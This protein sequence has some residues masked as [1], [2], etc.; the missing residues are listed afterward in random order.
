MMRRAWPGDTFG[1]MQAV[2]RL[3]GHDQRVIVDAGLGIAGAGLIAVAAWGA[4]RLIGS[5]AITGPWWLLA[6]LPLLLGVPLILRR[7]APLQ[8]WL[9]IWAVVA[10][11]S[12]F[13]DN[14]LRGLAFTFVLFAAAYSLGAHASLRRAVVGL[15][16]VA[17]VVVEISHHGRL[18]LAFAQ[19]GG[20]KAVVL[21]LLQLVAFWLAGVFV[22]ARRQAASLAA[23]SAA[24]QRQAD[25]AT[26]AERA[27]IAREMH[28]IV[29]HHLSVI[30]LQAAGAR[31]SGKPAG[32]T[33][34]KIENSARQ[35]LAETRRLLGVLR[36]P[37]EETGLAPQPGIRDLDALAASVRAAG[38]PV[39][40]VIDAG[41][42]AV[43]ATVDVSV[44]RIVQEALTNVLKHAGPARADVTIGC[45]Q[46]AVTIEVTDDGTAEP[47]H[48]APVGGHGL[49]G[50]RE[51]AT[52]FG[53]DLAAGPR[54]GGG[55]AVRARLPLGDG[56]PARVPS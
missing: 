53:G 50:M 19:D 51:R 20:K 41:L 47:G 17:P 30:V 52:V 55:Y 38:L 40:L 37:D 54:P 23:R 1:G 15:I 27:R 18:G 46:D 49:A 36:D 12:L 10:L 28:D 43:P 16:V 56:L 25:Q 4:P 24:L 45:G 3:A 33:L 34:E 2:G 26:A 22:H 8:M 7:R 42:A 11:L 44:Y 14:S 9:A 48:Q 29:A 13:G 6:L 21:S 5:T 32:A 39:N 31:A 35:G